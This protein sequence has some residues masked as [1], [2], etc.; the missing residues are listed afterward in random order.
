MPRQS[1]DMTRRLLI[2]ASRGVVASAVLFLANY[3]GAI[4]AVFFAKA[5]SGS[6]LAWALIACGLAFVLG[7]DGWR[8]FVLGR[9]SDDCLRWI[10]G[11]AHKRQ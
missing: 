1:H 6:D 8:Q 9:L 2:V 11:A 7:I 4:A 10:L 5:F 3:P